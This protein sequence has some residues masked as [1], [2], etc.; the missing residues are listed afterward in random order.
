MKRFLQTLPHAWFEKIQ[1]ASILGT[2][3]FLGCI[4]GEFVALEL[5]KDKKAKLS[6]LQKHKL[7]SI[8]ENAYGKAFVLTPENFDEVS[9]KLK[10]LAMKGWIP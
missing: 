4:R 9:A 8:R 1:Q 5:K 7:W 3:D 6:K 10:N 2:P